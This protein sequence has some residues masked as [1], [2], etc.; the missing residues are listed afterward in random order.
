MKRGYAIA[1]LAGGFLSYS[2]VA[3]ASGLPAHCAD[4]NRE[5]EPLR[6]AKRSFLSVFGGIMPIPSYYVLVA[7]S[8]PAH[9]MAA[10]GLEGEGIL[11]G[12]L[13]TGRIEDI[14]RS[15][16]PVSNLTL[17]E[18]RKIGSVSILL[19]KAKDARDLGTHALMKSDR[20]FLYVADQ[21][22]DAWKKMVE[23]FFPIKAKPELCEP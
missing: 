2:V 23:G 16:L 12:T 6:D 22:S 7:S 20:E 21:D 9:R 4:G 5:L 19:Y 13:I 3:C 15:H 11:V 14:E 1:L 18:T 10:I 17:S 8:G